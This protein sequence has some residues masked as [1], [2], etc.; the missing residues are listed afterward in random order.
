MQ[1][2]M[3]M[4]ALFVSV[5]CKGQKN[6]GT[7]ETAFKFA[8]SLIGNNNFILQRYDLVFPEKVQQVLQKVQQAM[9]ENKGWFQEYFNK[10]YKEG[11]GLPYNEKFGVTAEEYKLIKNI[12][13]TPPSP[14]AVA[15]DTIIVLRTDSRLK[16]KCKNRLSVLDFLELDLGNLCLFVDADIIPYNKPIHALQSPFGEW[17]GYNWK[18]V[19][20][21]QEYE[22]RADSLTATLIDVSVGKTID[23]RKLLLVKVQKVNSGIKK[24][25][26][27]VLGILLPLVV[28]TGD[29]QLKKSF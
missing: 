7:K 11:E 25:N 14:V 28:K 24:A 20:T 4:L 13:K 23:N 10:N 16:F 18:Y 21:N 8:D 6:D 2:L 27:D 1:K 5:G 26:V 3:M 17:T 12:D 22:L 19:K 9:T 15:E 29:G